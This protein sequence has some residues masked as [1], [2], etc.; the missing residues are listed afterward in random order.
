[1]IRL[2]KVIGVT[3]FFLVFS[4]LFQGAI[5]CGS[6]YGKVNSW[7]KLVPKVIDAVAAIDIV[8]GFDIEITG[9][10]QPMAGGTGFVVSPDGYIVTNAHVVN[11]RDIL[12]LIDPQIWVRFQDGKKFIARETYSDPLVDIAII[13][14]K[15]KNLPYLEFEKIRPLEVGQEI[16]VIGN[17]YPFE[18]TVTDGIISNIDLI[19]DEEVFF[20]HTGSTNFGCSGGP[21]L[22]KYGKVVGVTVA[23][24]PSMND[25]YFGIAGNLAMISIENLVGLKL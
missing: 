9:K 10:Y 23:M 24:V 13:K 21:I 2:E 6:C 11:A 5:G 20:Q 14:I 22:S 4:L 7:D 3:L 15:A 1:M 19:L 25:V 17:A 8:D 18:F 16:M 12:P